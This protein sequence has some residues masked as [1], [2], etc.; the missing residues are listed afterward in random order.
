LNYLLISTNKYGY[1]PSPRV[2][3]EDEMQNLITFMSQ[4]SRDLVLEYY[5]LDT[6][7][8]DPV[9]FQASPV[10]LL[11]PTNEIHDFWGR[12]N[13]V[14]KILRDCA[15]QLWPNSF[16]E[17]NAPSSRHR[18]KYYFFSI[19]EEEIHNGM[20]WV[21]EHLQAA[22]VRVCRRILIHPD[23]SPISHDSPKALPA[24]PTSEIFNYVDADSDSQ[25]L[26]QQQQ[27][28]IKRCFNNSLD[29]CYKEFSPVPLLS[30]QSFQKF[31]FNPCHP[32]HADYL[33]QF[34]I[35]TTNC[36]LDSL[37]FANEN[38]AVE[39][40]PLMDEI[41]YHWKYALDC[42]ESYC[43]YSDV[44]DTQTH[45]RRY[46][47]SSSTSSIFVLHGTSGCGKT[48][49]FGYNSPSVNSTA[50]DHSLQTGSEVTYRNSVVTA[51]SVTTSD[52]VATATHA[53]Q[54]G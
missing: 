4:A 3:P 31:E 12:I 39:N 44:D 40:H 6:N 49:A 10:Y 15:L 8:V 11:R 21:P 54:S 32:E 52:I 46:M 9:T 36:L 48:C 5:A 23:K 22:N 28:S 50:G 38:L 7:S 42:L 30:Q 35:H 51:D 47:E 1:R 41:C 19:T 26:L 18:I 2:I 34:A 24:W 14:T 27:D 53:S 37:V 43:S 25:S 16:S 45:I 17:M 29:I 13:E 20:Y 33:N